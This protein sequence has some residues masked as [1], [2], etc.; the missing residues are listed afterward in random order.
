MT[1]AEWIMIECGLFLLGSIWGS[2]L[3]VLVDRVPKGESIFLPGSHCNSCWH[4]LAAS[5]LIPFKVWIFNRGQCAY[6]GAPIDPQTIVSEF[7]TALLFS[8]APLLFPDIKR[9][10]FLLV[11]FSFALPLSLID[12]RLHR[13]PHKLTLP[14]G[15]AGLAL[16]WATLGSF[17][18]HLEGLLPSVLGFLTG[19]LPLWLLATFY[20][21]G[22]GMGDAFWLGAIGTFVGPIGTLQTLLLSSFS[23]TLVSVLALLLFKK[24]QDNGSWRTLKIPF[25]P[26]LSAGG[27]TVILCQ[28]D[29]NKWGEAI[30]HSLLG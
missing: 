14:A 19:F 18:F 30:S 11:F 13:L 7:F 15:F 20:P 23:A 26:F 10:L 29:L 22:M 3:G 25:G 28:H 27:I 12:L 9:I 21:Q 8:A 16:T 1:F 2:F 4:P 6:C 17:Q 5:D 24:E